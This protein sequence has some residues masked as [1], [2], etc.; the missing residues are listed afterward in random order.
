MRVEGSYEIGA[1][2]EAVWRWLN[3]PEVLAACIPGVQTLTQTAEHSYDAVLNV[4]IG[5][6]R[7]TYVGK[8]EIRD[9]SPPHSYTMHVQGNGPGAFITGEG[10]FKLS[11]VGP[12]ATR[13][14]VGGEAQ[15]GGILAR[16]GQRMLGGA[17]KSLMNQFFDG[18]KKH[19][20]ASEKSS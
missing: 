14:D 5:A 18:L 6:V 1:G 19:A 16:V 3:D 10:H 4:G 8:V 15:I 13:I 7:G 11:E 17:S 2:I 9:A 20:A 12:E